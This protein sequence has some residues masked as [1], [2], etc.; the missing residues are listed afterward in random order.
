MVCTAT[1]Q[2]IRRTAQLLLYVLVCAGLICKLLIPSLRVQYAYVLI[3][4]I[5]IFHFYKHLILKFL[6]QY[7]MGIYNSKREE[8]VVIPE[9]KLNYS[10]PTTYFRPQSTICNIIYK[11]HSGTGAIYG[12]EFPEGTRR[13]LL[14]TCNQVL[15]ISRVDEVVGLR[16]EFKDKTIGNVDMTPD[17]VKW[18]WT[19]PRE[20]LN[21]TVIEFSP[22]ALTILS[23]MQFYRLVSATPKRDTKVTVFQYDGTVSSGSIIDVN[24]DSIQYKIESE[25]SLGSPLIN[26]DLDVVGIHAGPLN[27]KI[28]SNTAN[29]QA[30]NIQS[31]LNAY[32]E[33]VLKMLHGKTENELWLEKINHDS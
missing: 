13:T 15:C 2:E 4:Y 17:W 1:R 7:Q 9:Q 12:F 28:S 8:A 24:G 21:A 30:I 25:I 32:K 29:N 18:L 16:L 5:S 23:R 10:H 27:T 22:T 11:E 31:I 26:E 20:Q 6:I 33:Y 3:L 14:I 19:S